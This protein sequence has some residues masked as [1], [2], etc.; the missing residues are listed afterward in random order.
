MIT[1]APVPQ[2]R[3]W[4]IFSA[5]GALCVL[6]GPRPSLAFMII[7]SWVFFIVVLPV[8]YAFL[9]SI[10]SL[11]LFLHFI[12][13]CNHTHIL[14]CFRCFHSTV[15]LY[16][17][18]KWLCAVRLFLLRGGVPLCA[19]MAC[20][21]AVNGHPVYFQFLAVAFPQIS[22]TLFGPRVC[23]FVQGVDLGMELIVK[24]CAYPQLDQVKAKLFFK[25]VSLFASHHK[26]PLLRGFP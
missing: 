20:C 10:I 19:F 12:Q 24:G 16:R 1:C 22:R 9:K 8:Y 3:E 25:S 18:P 11:Y 15:C 17:S 4:R 2:V 13:I 14:L 23:R 7:A 5:Q 21:V 26:S 6:S